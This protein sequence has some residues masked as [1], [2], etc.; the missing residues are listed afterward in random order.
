MKVKRVTA[1]GLF[2]KRKRAAIQAS[3]D[4]LGDFSLAEWRSSTCAE[5]N[6]LSADELKEINREADAYNRE[7]EQSARKTIEDKWR[8][9]EEEERARYVVDKDTSH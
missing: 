1:F 9:A 2:S 3:A 4:V 6:A 8:P 7:A 5:F